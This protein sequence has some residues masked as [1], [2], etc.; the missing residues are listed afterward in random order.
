M[1]KMIYG[2]FAPG[3]KEASRA[4]LLAES[5]RTF[6]GEYSSLPFLM[7]L[8]QG[9]D[10]LTKSQHALIES[11][12]VK[13]T[14][15]EIDPTAASF[16]FAGK[17]AASA[18][19]EA[20]S[21]QRASQLVWMDDGTL[22]V[23]PVDQLL[24]AHESRFGYRPV[25]HLLIGSP[26]DKPIDSFWDF[27]YQSCGVSEGDIYPM[28]SSTDQIK[29]RPY[30]N[31]GMLVVRPEDQ[32]LQRWRDT[33]LEVYQDHRLLKLY[34]KN[35]LYTIFIH[36]AVL[37]GCVISGYQQKET[38]ELPHEINYPLHMHAEYPPEM[39]PSTL[40]QLVSFRYESYFSK[41]G[42]LDLIEVDPPLK[43]WLEQREKLLS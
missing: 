23:N 1:H 4:L 33:F 29:M 5:I 15:F 32:L 10:H 3:R 7:M 43:D 27:I 13:L 11:L 42:W 6:A 36:Q 8:S 25:D 41:P 40:N 21:F 30:I 22:V 18:A 38:L 17:V 16:P 12:D 9:H 14:S 19:A 20:I 28:I 31:T 26:Y 37:A 34:E 24:L 35:Q 39:K 2:C